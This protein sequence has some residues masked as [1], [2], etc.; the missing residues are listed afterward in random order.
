[1]TPVLLGKDLVLEAWSPK[2]EDKQVPGLIKRTFGKNDPAETRE[3][4]QPPQRFHSL[5][6]QEVHPMAT[7]MV[8]TLMATNGN[9]YGNY[10]NPY[11]NS[12]GN[13]YGLGAQQKVGRKV[14]M[15]WWKFFWETF[16]RINVWHIYPQF[17][18]FMVNQ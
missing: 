3:K 5:T 13:P 8:A 1:M 17:D 6:S 14:S 10:G 15:D 12:Y 4:N 18:D 9:T 11:G 16:S 2:I 7:L